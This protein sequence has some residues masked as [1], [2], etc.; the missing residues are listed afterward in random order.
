MCIIMKM[1]N[2]RTAADS[3]VLLFLSTGAVNST[4]QFTE[5]AGQKLPHYHFQAC[6]FALAASVRP[7]S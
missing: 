7:L 5:L 1:E 6:A 3:N 4:C 2:V